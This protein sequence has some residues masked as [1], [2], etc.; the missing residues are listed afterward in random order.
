MMH[1]KQDVVTYTSRWGRHKADPEDVQQA[2]PLTSAEVET[3]G[4]G[5]LQDQCTASKGYKKDLET[6]RHVVQS[7]SS[8]RPSAAVCKEQ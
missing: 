6:A 7:T 4:C 3:V 8:Q 1:A 5:G 2:R